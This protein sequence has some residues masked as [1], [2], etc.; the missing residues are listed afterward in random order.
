[1]Q[2]FLLKVGLISQEALAELLQQALL[3]M[4]QGHF[5]AMEYL[6]TVLVTKLL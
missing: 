2:P 5:T 3:D 4:H 1:L 6:L